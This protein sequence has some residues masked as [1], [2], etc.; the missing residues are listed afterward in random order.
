MDMPQR[1]VQGLFSCARSLCSR[2]CLRV[3]IVSLTVM[4]TV[5]GIVWSSLERMMLVPLDQAT[6]LSALV[7]PEYVFLAL[8]VAFVS[9]PTSTAGNRGC[10]WGWGDEVGECW[11]LGSRAVCTP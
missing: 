5:G 8:L 6:Q 3:C 1:T 4:L 11:V 10:R 2:Q 9:H 7:G